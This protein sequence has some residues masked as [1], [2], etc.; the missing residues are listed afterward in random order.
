MPSC[1]GLGHIIPPVGRLDARPTGEQH[2]LYMRVPGPITQPGFGPRAID[3]LALA[4][5][6]PTLDR[7]G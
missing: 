3:P 5:R 7:L 6:A 2:D 1:E 4:S